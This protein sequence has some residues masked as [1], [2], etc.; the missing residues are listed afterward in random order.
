MEDF[1]IS[2]TQLCFLLGTERDGLSGRNSTTRR[3]FF[4]ILMVGN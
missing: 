1:D 4:K 2:E 3:W